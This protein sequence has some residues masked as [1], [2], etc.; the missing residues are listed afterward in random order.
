[1]LLYSIS[2]LL[3]ICIIQQLAVLP[4]LGYFLILPISLLL[5]IGFRRYKSLLF[6]RYLSIA[7]A[8]AFWATLFAQHYLESRLVE[9]LAGMN[10]VVEGKVIGI[11]TVNGSVQRFM[12]DID[13]FQAED[14]ALQEHID[15]DVSLPK[16][17]RISWY[18]STV[19]VG[20]GQKWRFLVRL[21]PPHGFLNPGGFDY[22]A[23]LYQQGIHATGYVRESDLNRRLELANVYSIDALRQALNQKINLHL[24]DSQYRG[25]VAALA[26]GNRSFIEKQQW[27]DLI[28]TGT[29]HLMAISGLHIGLA[30][31]FGYWITRRTLPGAVMKKI[32]AQ[33]ICVGVGVLFALAYALLAGLSI[34]T[35]RALIM[36]MCIATAIISKRHF[37]SVNV[38]SVALLLVLIIDPVSVLSAGFWFSFLAVAAIFTLY[39]NKSK[40]DINETTDGVVHHKKHTV[41]EY[42]KTK[43]WQWGGLQLVIALALFPLSLLMFQQTSM[44]APVANFILVP[45]VSFL[46]VPLVLLAIVFFAVY[47]PVAILIL[48]LANVL[49]E[50]I[51]PFLHFLAELPLSHWVQNVQSL[52]LT[53]LAMTGIAVFLSPL[54][55]R[56]RIIGVFLILPLFLP[57][58]KQ[59][60]NGE[61][62]VQLLDVGQGLSVV[63]ATQNHVL[64]YDT[65]ARFSDELDSGQ[66]V[67]IP[68]LITMGV[69]HIDKL[70]ISHGDNDH[71]GGANSILD[72]FP[73]TKVIGQDL[74]S[75]VTDDKQAC[76]KGVI[77]TW[78]GVIFEF[79]H[80]GV[81]I[82]KKRNNHSCVLKVTGLG[83]SLLLTG[84]IEQP[85]EKQLL[86]N[87]ANKLKSTVLVVP[88]HGSK[89]SSSKP[90][91]AAVNPKIALFAVGYRNRYRLPAIDVVQRYRALSTNPAV[92]ILSSAS[93]GAIRLNFQSDA[94]VVIEDQY[95]INQ[96]K[97]W[98]HQLPEFN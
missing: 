55:W 58:Q 5:S 44:I 32:S 22:E 16:R 14:T 83:G 51:W 6:L 3:G 66:A 49:L 90:W 84:D 54:S 29:N 28:K 59:R 1:M 76:R 20:A 41:V 18:Y 52:G 38:L 95:R 9:P 64:V 98:N 15:N 26:V 56:F 21:K 67:V 46:V 23:W 60:L 8:G 45:F 75:L 62:D 27:D 24:I 63:I 11:P 79:L 70:I 17:V 12:L 50:F 34:P 73:H 92:R 4:S 7:I 82:Q 33:Q 69:K 87:S 89:T 78:D 68:V 65:G 39:R 97:Y 13:S 35:Q 77:W 93:S 80:P 81:K 30:A 43:L 85:I 72:A 2:F 88:H 40:L 61:F 10:I 31:A 48:K 96:S 91:L 37:S 74:Q 86:K 71:I 57:S 94:G 53:V 42:S 47:E 25:L 36:L 19:E